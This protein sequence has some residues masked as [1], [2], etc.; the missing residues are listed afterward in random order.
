MSEKREKEYES[1]GMRLQQGNSYMNIYLYN[2][3]HPQLGPTN[4]EWQELYS[5]IQSLQ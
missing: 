2:I 3:F 1:I 5:L 4:F